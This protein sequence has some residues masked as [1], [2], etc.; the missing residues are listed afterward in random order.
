MFDRHAMA[1]FTVL[2][3]ILGAGRVGFHVGKEWLDYH[4]AKKPVDLR[5]HFRTIDQDLA[6]WE[7][8]GGDRELPAE[9]VETLGTELYLERLYARDGK[10]REGLIQLHIAYYTGM[11]DQVPHIPDRCMVASGFRRQ[12][13]PANYPL[14]LPQVR[15]KVGDDG[16]RETTFRN[17]I[18]G[19]DVPVH[20][21][22]GDFKLRTIEFSHDDYPGTVTYGGYFFIANGRVVATPEQVKALA[23]RR[24]EE[25]AYYCKVQFVMQSD[26]D[27]TAEEYVAEVSDL[28]TPLLPQIMN[29]LPDWPE[30]QARMAAGEADADHTTTPEA[31]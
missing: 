28:L 3:V 4:F 23:F 14:E 29:C 12:A 27:L 7:S 5:W 15:W 20:L 30:V 11:I 10:P 19:R 24:S 8:V 31:G 22:E 18:T 9:I 25:Y 26:D 21:P 16:V 1:A 2:L 13:A 17:S 6:S